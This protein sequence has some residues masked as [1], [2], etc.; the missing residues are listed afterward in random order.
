MTIVSDYIVGAINPRGL[1]AATA[2]G[3]MPEYEPDALD[4]WIFDKG[5]D[6]N[7][8]GIKGKYLAMLGNAPTNNSASITTASAGLHGLETPFQDAQTQTFCAVVKRPA[9][10]AI[11]CGASS[12][13]G[14]DGGDAI[15]FNAALTQ[16]LT[17]NEGSSSVAGS[18]GVA[19]DDW[20]FVALSQ[21]QGSQ[22]YYLG[23]IGYAMETHTKLVSASKVA[24]GNGYYNIAAYMDGLEFHSFMFFDT[25]KSLDNIEAIYARSKI[26]AARRGIAIL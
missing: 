23:G 5:N 14:G 4:H 2:R 22:I 1:V 11:I 17:R 10:S 18:S 12:D 3:I 13:V 21:E 7:L 16:G 8:R 25:A 15:L 20:C 9:S 19:E 26:S 6:A 24:L